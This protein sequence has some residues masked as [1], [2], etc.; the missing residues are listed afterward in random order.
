MGHK[1]KAIAHFLSARHGQ[2]AFP[3]RI[4]LLLV[5]FVLLLPVVS[6][7]GLSEGDL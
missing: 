5:A 4:A 2:G 6:T 3:R 7:L 1:S